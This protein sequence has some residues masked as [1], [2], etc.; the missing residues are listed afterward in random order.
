MQ[1]KHVFIGQRMN[2][3][4]DSRLLKENETREIYNL[5]SGNTSTNGKG[6]LE[7]LKSN[8]DILTLDIN[9][10]Y[11]DQIFPIYYNVEKSGSYTRN[12]CTTG[13][14]GSSVSYVVAAGLYY[15]TID[16]DDAD[17]QAEADITTNG[18]SYANSHGACTLIP[19][20][21]NV[22]K[23]APF[24][25][26]DCGDGYTGS[27]TE[28]TVSAHTYSSLVSQ[29]V[30]DALAQA[31]VDTNGQAY[32]NAHGTC[33]L[34]DAT[35]NYAYTASA[36]V[37]SFD[38]KI[39]GVDV[40]T[41][42]VSASGAHAITAGDVITSTLAVVLGTDTDNGVITVS[43]VSDSVVLVTDPETGSSYTCS[44]T[45]TFDPTDG[46]INLIAQELS[47]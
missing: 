1:D 4:D 46:D 30:A 2:L 36:T 28:Y 47:A 26:N 6:C 15:S 25:R 20:Y 22:S 19:V 3:D 14:A 11:T 29:V 33:A 16:Q 45:Y 13:Y 10:S 5:R 37:S 24:T 7:T 35:L 31:D 18:Q 9:A 38:L 8:L 32:A 27:T 17:D 21:W 42:G 43:R 12:N 40:I 41:S 44:I 23:Y 34:T 39:N